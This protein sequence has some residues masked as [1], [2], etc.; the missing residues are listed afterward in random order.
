VARQDPL[1]RHHHRATG[2]QQHRQSDRTPAGRHARPGT[3]PP[4]TARARRSMLDRIREDSCNAFTVRRTTGV[5]LQGPEGA[6][7]LRALSASTS[8]LDRRLSSA[9][10]HCAP[11]PNAATTLRLEIPVASAIYPVRLRD[12]RELS[13]GRTPCS[14]DA[15]HRWTPAGRSYANE[16]PAP[17]WARPWRPVP[18]ANGWADQSPPGG[19]WLAAIDAVAKSESTPASSEAPEPQRNGIR[20]RIRESCKSA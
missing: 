18:C 19:K 11:I 16:Q 13:F 17:S 12:L 1:Q 15:M 8:E 14:A 2:R 9:S 10:V 20:F 7:R 6:Q 5:K 4:C 3:T